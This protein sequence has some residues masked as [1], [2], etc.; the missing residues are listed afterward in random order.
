MPGWRV[1]RPATPRTMT[2]TGAGLAVVAALAD[3][4]GHDMPPTGRQYGP[5]PSGRLIFARQL[6]ATTVALRLGVLRE[7]V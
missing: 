3:K 6:S 2:S 7:K 4:L 1:E 5:R